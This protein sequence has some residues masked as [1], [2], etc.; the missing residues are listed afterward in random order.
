[1]I[2]GITGKKGS[3]KNAIA[4]ILESEHGFLVRALADPIKWAISEIFGW[5]L[6]AMDDRKFKEEIDPEFG[7]SP[8]QVMQDMG[9]EWGQFHLCEMFPE[10]AKVT[11]R[12]LWVKRLLQ[13]YYEDYYEEDYLAVPDVRYLHEVEA[14]REYGAYIIKVID[15]RIESTDTHLSETE[16]DQIKPDVTIYNSGTLDDLRKQVLLAYETFQDNY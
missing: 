12:N 6:I 9:T 5:S 1:M 2:I 14:L 7:V 3:G 10:F 4:N 16:L 8:R 11:G 15:P 13:D